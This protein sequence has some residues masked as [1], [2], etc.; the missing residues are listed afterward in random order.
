MEE[1]FAL[2]LNTATIELLNR[3]IEDNLLP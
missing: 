2:D 1:A 3:V